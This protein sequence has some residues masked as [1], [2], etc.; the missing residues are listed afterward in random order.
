VIVPMLLVLGAKTRSTHSTK[1][2][3]YSEHSCPSS[4]VLL[5][6]QPSGQRLSY[7]EN[8]RGKGKEQKKRKSK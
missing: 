7:C 6:G 1:M 3:R 4:R 8:F 2:S 5:A